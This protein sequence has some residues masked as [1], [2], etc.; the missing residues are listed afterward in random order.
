MGILTSSG[1]NVT[2]LL[3]T[4]DALLLDAPLA[5]V[6]SLL[7]LSRLGAGESLRPQSHR[8][9]RRKAISLT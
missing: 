1:V 6:P 4:G 7:F 9:G 5:A 3:F 2:L 8:L